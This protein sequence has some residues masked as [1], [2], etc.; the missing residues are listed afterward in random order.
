MK[1]LQEYVALADDEYP[2]TIYADHNLA[3]HMD[4]LKLVL[5]RYNVRECT[6]DSIKKNQT[7]PAELPGLT[8]GDVYVVK[9]IL[10]SE[11]RSAMVLVREI[12]SNFQPGWN[13]SVEIGE[14][15]NAKTSSTK[16]KIEAFTGTVP[17]SL[18]ADNSVD[19][20]VLY[21]RSRIEAAMKEAEK[22]AKAK[23]AKKTTI[24]FIAAH[25][26]LAEMGIARRRGLYLCEHDGSVLSVLQSI[27]DQF[28]RAGLDFVA[29]P[30]EIQA[31][32]PEPAPATFDEYDIPMDPFTSLLSVLGHSGMQVAQ[33][34]IIADDN[35][36]KIPLACGQGVDVHQ[37]MTLTTEAPDWNIEVQTEGECLVL[38]FT[39][40]GPPA[41][42]PKPE[43][44][45]GDD[46]DSHV[47]HGASEF[48]LGDL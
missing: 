5:L 27:G 6:F 19:G 15:R 2:I 35:V 21:G 18:K 13:I 41:E 4:R 8:F 40:S 34:A 29:S 7:S 24:K 44:N 10:G 12:A 45:V 17:G 48:S 39:K 26:T 1:R 42:A 16:D 32:L 31:L 37:L 20:S 30:A 47:P 23:A 33:D 11:P 36:V 14:G 43:F 25:D 38:V 22:R 46:W 9:A 3:D 28:D